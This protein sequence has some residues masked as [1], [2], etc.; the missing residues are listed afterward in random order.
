[1]AYMRWHPETAEM[2]TFISLETIPPGWLDHHPTDAAKRLVRDGNSPVVKTASVEPDEIPA[3]RA[4]IIAQLRE[5]NIA[6]RVTAK[7]P[8]LYAQ[9]L[10]AV[11]RETEDEGNT[12]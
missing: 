7:T 6:F 8:V 1:M 11:E 10:S 5:R 9:L 2:Q 3:T 4:E 12:V